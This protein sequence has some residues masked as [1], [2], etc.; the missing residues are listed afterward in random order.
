MTTMLSSK[1]KRGLNEVIYE[2]IRGTSFFDEVV[3]WIN[4]N[5]QPEDVFDEETLIN[6][7]KSHYGEE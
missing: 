1:A 3:Q 6:W 7:A 4:G 2:E 5:L